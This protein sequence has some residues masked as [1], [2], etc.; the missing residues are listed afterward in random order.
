MDKF[1]NGDRVI[2]GNTRDDDLD[3]ITGTVLGIYGN[4]IWPSYIVT[5]DTPYAKMPDWTAH[6]IIGSCL[7]KNV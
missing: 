7:S 4:D 1:V 5:L 2:I 3:G 6:V